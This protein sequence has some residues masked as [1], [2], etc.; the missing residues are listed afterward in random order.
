MFSTQDPKTKQEKKK[1]RVR[2]RIVPRDMRASDVGVRV[3]FCACDEACRWAPA[4]PIATEKGPLRAETRTTHI[5]A[6]AACMCFRSVLPSNLVPPSTT[7][8]LPPLGWPAKHMPS[9][10]LRLA[11]T[12]PR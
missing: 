3:E 7:A 6:R 11:G 2:V 9:S 5:R 1:Y 10:I 12:N 8:L 4:P